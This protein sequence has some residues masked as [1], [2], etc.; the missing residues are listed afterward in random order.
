MPLEENCLAYCARAYGLKNSEQIPA[1]AVVIVYSEIARCRERGV[2]SASEIDRIA[3]LICNSMPEK[4]QVYFKN[5]NH[6]PNAFDTTAPAAAAVSAGASGVKNC[7]SSS[8]GNDAAAEGRKNSNKVAAEGVD[9]AA[10]GASAPTPPPRPPVPR[11]G[12]KKANPIAR[13]L[14]TSIV[15]G[16]LVPGAAAKKNV[17][18]ASD[19]FT[20]AS[21]RQIHRSSSYGVAAARKNNNARSPTPDTDK[22]HQR[23]QTQQQQSRRAAALFPAVSPAGKKNPDTRAAVEGFLQGVLRPKSQMQFRTQNSFRRL[24]RQ[25]LDEDW[26]QHVLEEAKADAAQREQARQREL[27]A[28]R[29]RA[30]EVKDFYKVK[31]REVEH[32]FLE[33][34]A[35][36]IESQQWYELNTHLEKQQQLEMKQKRKEEFLTFAQ[37]AAEHKA[38]LRE[39]EERQKREGAEVRKQLEQG[40]VQ[41]KSAQRERVVESRTVYVEALK[42]GMDIARKTKQ[43]SKAQEKEHAQRIVADAQQHAAL[44]TQREAEEKER[45]LA[46]VRKQ[47]QLQTV[48]QRIFEEKVHAQRLEKE[49]RDAERVNKEVERVEEQYRQRR[50]QERQHQQGLKAELQAALKE[51]VVVHEKDKKQRERDEAEE[52]KMIQEA[53]RKEMEQA[54]RE[55]EML[56]KKR[57]ET[58]QMQEESIAA[59][60]AELMLP[61]QHKISEKRTY[62]SM[63]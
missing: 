56:R 27:E 57:E 11:C 50:I 19:F 6:K 31:Q 37:Q 10:A 42:E 24:Q 55:A 13:H 7:S 54:K 1:A 45:R 8:S 63:L 25:K 48:T 61:P 34:E 33:R 60:N 4:A 12:I 20:G 36:R 41:D 44:V 40:V 58:K 52:Q 39:E 46:R 30:A 17:V 22:S 18:P 59:R 2:L 62:K 47:E 23:P 28:K 51:T 14:T 38:K 5:H 32:K 49:R 21:E 9:A 26:N 35:E 16:V 29:Q 3:G 43:Q 53:V 15:S